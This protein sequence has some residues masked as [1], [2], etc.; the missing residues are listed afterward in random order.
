MNNI[1]AKKMIDKSDDELKE[2]LENRFDYQEE[3]YSAALYEL[4]KRRKTKLDHIPEIAVQN[5]AAAPAKDENEQK[6]KRKSFTEVLEALAPGKGYYITPIIIYINVLVYA[7]MIVKNVHPLEPDI[8]SL[9]QWGGN[10]RHLTMDGE[11]WRLLSSTFLHGGLFHLLFN[12][13]ALLY[14]GKEIETQIGSNRFLFAYLTT[15]ILAS[16]T[17]MAYYDNIVSVGASGAIFG[18]YGLLITLLLLKVIELPP[19]TRKNFV[20]SV[21]TFVL[22]N[23]LYGL[24]QE[25]IDNAAHIGGLVS[26]LIIGGL[27]FVTGKKAFNTS[28][29]VLSLSLLIYGLIKTAP[30]YISN[31]LGNYNKLMN[32]FAI[33]EE[34]AISI[35]RLGSN[36]SDQQVLYIIQEEGIPNWRK[37]HDIISQMDSIQNLPPELK[38][39]NK[40]LKQYCEYRIEE[41]MLLEKSISEQTNQYDQQISE[42]HKKINLILQQMKGEASADSSLHVN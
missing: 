40:L 36:A 30:Q 29:L 11:W 31:E 2:I 15:G 12:M 23:L 28:I 34:K 13:Y 17:S 41:F 21:F 22:Y 5:E 27:L 39:Q 18:M 10:L 8:A 1:F 42:Y 24:N 32:E 37:C 6:A 20:T 26:G 38:E 33:F 4:E 7:I 14:I 9:I 3:A 35:S 16:M 25:G 19:S